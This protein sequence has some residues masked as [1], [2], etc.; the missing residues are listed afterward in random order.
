MR[1]TFEVMQA[2][3]EGAP[4]TEEEL[5]YAL[6]NVECWFSLHMFDIARGASEDP[7]TDKTRR[8]LAR[9]FENWHSGNKVPLDV[10]LKGSSMEPGISRDERMGRAAKQTSEVAVGLIDALNTL[11]KAP[12]PPTAGD[13]HE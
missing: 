4:A 1:T 11:R 5:R 9:A 6:R 7:I 8:G 13:G 3:Q 10:R 12:T 2:V